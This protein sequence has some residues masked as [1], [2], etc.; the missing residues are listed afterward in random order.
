MA[1][2]STFS[3]WARQKSGKTQGTL[4]NLCHSPWQSPRRGRDPSRPL[5][6]Q[7]PRILLAT[8]SL[9]GSLWEYWQGLGLM[10][11]H[12]RNGQS[13]RPGISLATSCL[14]YWWGSEL[15]RAFPKA[16]AS[17]CNRVFPPLHLTGSSDAPEGTS[18][19]FG[20]RAGPGFRTRDWK[21][22]EQLWSTLVQ[23]C[24]GIRGGRLMTS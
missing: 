12:H 13:G 4:S 2:D 15:K 21:S 1:S 14:A 16:R 7:I 10:F 17:E 23:S 24:R 18:V 8:G 19:L 20:L 22:A 6:F 9:S 5:S 11:A 3:K